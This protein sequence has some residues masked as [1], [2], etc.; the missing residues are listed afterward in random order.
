LTAAGSET[1]VAVVVDAA[2]ATD[3]QAVQIK[4]TWDSDQSGTIDAVTIPYRPQEPL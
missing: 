4:V 3:M 1:R 2:L